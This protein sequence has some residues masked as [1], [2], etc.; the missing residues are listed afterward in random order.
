MRPLAC[1]PAPDQANVDDLRQVVTQAERNS[2]DQATKDIFDEV[3]INTIEKAI[4]LVPQ[5][6]KTRN[7]KS[8]NEEQFTVCNEQL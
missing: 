3:D 8:S 7:Y 6:A 2:L 4:R 5:I 1:V